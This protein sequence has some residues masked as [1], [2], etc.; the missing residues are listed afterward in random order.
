MHDKGF[1][2]K[3]RQDQQLHWM[4]DTIRQNLEA[5]FFRHP[6]V[7]EAL[8]QT[9]RKSRYKEIIPPQSGANS[10]I[11]LYKNPDFLIFVS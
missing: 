9:Q 6:K 8:A 7:L 10:L 11:N 3:Q 1:F 4:L 2:Q 5:D